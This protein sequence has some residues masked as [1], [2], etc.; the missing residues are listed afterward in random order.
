MLHMANNRDTL[1]LMHYLCSLG[2]V[3]Y[4][5]ATP[6][7]DEKARVMTVHHAEQCELHFGKCVTKA[8]SRVATGP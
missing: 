8:D 1:S 5:L 2:D 4:S 3:T 7:S 6:I